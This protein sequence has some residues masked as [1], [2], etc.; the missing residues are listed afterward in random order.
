MLSPLI[1]TPQALDAAIA[2]SRH[3]RREKLVRAVRNQRIR[4]RVAFGLSVGVPI[5]ALVAFFFAGDYEAA[6]I[7]ALMSCM[8]FGVT[9]SAGKSGQKKAVD[10]LREI[11]QAM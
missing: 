4:T 11:D 1:D 6:V 9:Y 2:A 5:F 10:S 7:L 3:A 8:T